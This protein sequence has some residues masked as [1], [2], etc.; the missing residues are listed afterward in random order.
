MAIVKIDNIFIL[1]T[2][3]VSKFSM[4][5]IEFMFDNYEF[6]AVLVELDEDRLKALTDKNTRKNYFSIS[7]LREF[8]PFTTITLS[9]L[10]FL[11][12]LIGSKVGVMPGSDMIH[13]IKLALL[14]R[15]EVFLIDQPIILTMQ[16][17]QKVPL[18]EKIKLFFYLFLIF[19]A[20]LFNKKRKYRS[21]EDMMDKTMYSFKKKFPKF[22][23]YLVVKRNRFMVN[24][25]LKIRN[26][27]QGKI[28][29]V[30]GE[31]HRK[32][33]TSMLEK[34]IKKKSQI[35]SSEFSLF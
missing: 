20:S 3:H 1:G 6:S 15:K 11:Q 22:Y 23:Y 26:K 33:I 10:K 14:Y 29:V 30:V 28:L 7:L 35:I 13:A 18:K 19:P 8:G 27:V 5:Q 32:G 2:S 34:R 17:F 24:Q 31:G 25:I 4:K 21:I 12:D 9:L 16:D